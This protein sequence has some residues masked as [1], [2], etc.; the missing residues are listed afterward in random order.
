M[1]LGF[2]R[3]HR[4]WL[5][6]FLWLVIAA[7]IILYVPAFQGASAGSPAE[8]LARVGGLPIT[9]GEYQRAYQNQRQMYE[10]L[11][12]GRLDPAALR[13][14]GLEEQTFESLVMDRV[15]LL[16]A[17]RLGIAVPDEVLAKSILTTP[18]F[19]EQGRFVGAERARRMVESEGLSMEEFE[20]SFRARLLRDKLEALVTDGVSVTE[21]EAER[22]FRRRNE[23]VKAEYVLVDAARFRPQAT[24]DDQEIAARF[25]KRRESYQVP[26]KR[27]VSFILLDAD[28]LRPRVTVT[29]RDLELYYQ[30]HR[31]DFKQEEEACARHILVKVESSPGA[32]EGHPDAEARRIAQGLLDRVKAGEDF[33][34]LAK[35][36][37]ED[38]G[39]TQRGGDLGCFPKGSMLPTF[40]Q[41]AF[42]L[43]V[44]ATSELVKSPAGY[45]IIQVLSRKEESVLPLAQVKERIRQI[46]TGQHVQALASQQADSIAGTLGRGKS[47]EEAARGQGLAVQ[48]SP[49]LARGEA[50]EPL[51]S[52]SLLARVFEMKPGE[53]EK[54]GF[55]LPRGAAFIALT[56]V[57]PSH[58]PELKEAEAKIK[59]DLVEE[60]AL[61][62]ARLL[63]EEVKAKAAGSG[64]EKAAAAL[65]LVRKETPA[66]TSRGQAFGDLGSG[67]ALDEVAFTLKEKALSDPVRVAAGYAVLRVLEKKS[68]DPAAFSGQR[69]SFEESLRQERRTQLFQD[70]LSQARQR[71]P[72]ER[73]AEPFKRVVG[74][75][76]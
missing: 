24:V 50:K 29:E 9:V 70:Y 71:F 38:K 34:A 21:P 59:A 53:I 45:H 1:A 17:K 25:E 68:F 5:Y 7:F 4:R 72:V 48:K 75:G 56:E 3:R 32:K 62:K 37:S 57:Q 8:V 39:S 67:A 60:R 40:D 35:K 19:Q 49:P 61:E 10:Q 16:E 28:A 30:D 73:R 55:A 64:L 12:R 22:E 41:A 76:T 2:M 31:E 27:V 58:L 11:Y 14:L 52:P 51:N 26:E 65:G 20:A 44:G 15:T 23:Q 74:Q 63:A 69:A 42:S 33:S 13:R 46:V 66:L 36:S 47:L 54:E 6:G 43:E 18:A